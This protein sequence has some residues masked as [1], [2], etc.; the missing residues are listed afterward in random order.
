MSGLA[1]RLDRIKASFAEKASDEVKQVMG[2]A[3]ADLRASGILDRLPA[4]GAALPAHFELPDVDGAVV[5]SREL[6]ARGPLVISFYRGV[7]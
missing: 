4:V 1:E 5:R 7:W 6:L 3:T 2:R